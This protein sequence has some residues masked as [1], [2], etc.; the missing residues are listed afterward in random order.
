MARKLLKA[1]VALLVIVLVW[2]LFAGGDAEDLE[3]IDRI[4]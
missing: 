2:K 1:G 3:E 4:D